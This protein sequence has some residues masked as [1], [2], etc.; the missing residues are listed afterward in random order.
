MILK[1]YFP[2][3]IGMHKTDALR[4]MKE[5]NIIFRIS[6][7]DGIFYKMGTGFVQDRVNLNIQDNVITDYRFY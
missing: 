1:K 6:E 3:L 4:I 5:L 2:V 7:E